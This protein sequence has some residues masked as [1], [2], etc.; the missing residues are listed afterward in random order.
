MAITQLQGTAL[1]DRSAFISK[2]YTMLG[3]SLL[4]CCGGALYGLSMP[5]GAYFP[6][7]IAEFIVFFLCMGF[8]RAYPLNLAL[9]FLFT[10][11]S[12]LTLGPILNHYTHGYGNILPT[13]TATTALT[14]GGL[15]AY[16]HISKKDFSFLGGALFVGLMGIIVVGLIG[17]FVPAL[18]GNVLYAL[19]GVLL[20]SGYILYDTS[21]LMRR[22]EQDEYVAAT[23]SLYLDIINLFLFLLRL[24]AGGRR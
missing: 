13:V 21:N 14:F 5:A 10:T 9:L 16:V 11:L 19:A 12:G 4:F 7:M 2:V 1:V 24:F 8:R 15:S 22:Y 6:M 18:V 17:F 3:I 23:L 20:F